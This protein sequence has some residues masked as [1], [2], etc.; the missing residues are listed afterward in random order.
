MGKRRRPARLFLAASFALLV[1]SGLAQAQ[2]VAL[3]ASNT[4]GRGVGL[5]GAYPARL[6]ALLRAKGYSSRVENAG[7]SGDTTSGMLSRLD[8]AVP[9][10][11]RIVILDMGGGYFNNVR[12]G[13]SREQGQAD[14]AAIM[15]RLRARG[16]R[17]ISMSAA[18]LPRGPDGIH[19][20]LEGQAS[21]AARLLPQVISA[22]GRSGR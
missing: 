15:S 19:L 12:L 5:A 16:I 6:E 10:G 18:G 3:G 7:I 13:I 11:T 20:S 17:V 8:S 9:P 4:A 14:T 21:V 22:L 1:C 2:I